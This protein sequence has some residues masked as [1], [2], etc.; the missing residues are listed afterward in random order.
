[1]YQTRAQVSVIK[2]YVEFEELVEVDLPEPNIDRTEPTIFYTKC[3][4]CTKTII[5]QDYAKLNSNIIAEVIKPLVETGPS[6]K[7]TYVIVEV[8]SKFN[9]TISYRKIW[10]SKQKMI[11]KIFCG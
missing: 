9:Y 5:S 3:S 1:M 8:Q 2:L 11:A 4:P 10:L 7:V 6:L